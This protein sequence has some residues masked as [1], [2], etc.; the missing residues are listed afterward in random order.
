MNPWP[1]WATSPTVRAHLIIQLSVY[2]L[3]ILSKYSCQTEPKIFHLDIQSYWFK[4]ILHY[5]LIVSKCDENVWITGPET[6]DSFSNSTLCIMAVRL[7]VN[8][9]KIALTKGLSFKPNT[10][11]TNTGQLHTKKKIFRCAS[12]WRQSII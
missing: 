2:H 3:K 9:T 6:T 7:L 5:I 1:W 10:M 4:K 8:I 12:R 11:S